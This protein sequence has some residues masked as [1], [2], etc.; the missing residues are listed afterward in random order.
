MNEFS[1]QPNP[2]SERQAALRRIIERFVPEDAEFL[3]EMDEE[4]QLGYIYGQLLEM[5]E[6]PDEILHAFGVTE[7]SDEI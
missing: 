1:P 6:N 5:G 4:D 2:E 3:D 7:E